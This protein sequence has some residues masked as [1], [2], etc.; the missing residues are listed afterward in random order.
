MGFERRKSRVPKPLL[1][2]A[3][4][5][6]MPAQYVAEYV[7]DALRYAKHSSGRDGVIT[8]RS[9]REHFEAQLTK[10][11]HRVENG[12]AL[13]DLRRPFGANGEHCLDDLPL[14][15]ESKGLVDEPFVRHV[16]TALEALGQ[17][18]SDGEPRDVINPVVELD[19]KFDREALTRL[20]ETRRSV[21]NFV[22]LEGHDSLI[23][24]PAGPATHTPSVCNRQPG[25]LHIYST[26]ESVQRVLGLQNGN[27]GYRAAVAAVVVV[28]VDTRLS[29]G[30]SE[31]QQRYIDCG[32]FAM[33]FVWALHGLGVASCMLNWSM[34]NSQSDRLRS[35]ASIPAHEDIIMMIAVGGAAPE[36]RVARSPRRATDQVCYTAILRDD[37]VAGSVE[38]RTGREHET[39]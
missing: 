34:N 38:A 39:S 36:A 17:W 8:G 15:A 9:N 13:P 2:A 27:G 11:Y 28:S 22:P 14:A 29:T 32:L 12:L 6:L 4:K 31:R 24:T 3:A 7:R 16:R 5:L 19:P 35:V 33:S 37:F 10:D 21:R 26:G 20:F 1:R 25:R 18:N 30:V 23:Y